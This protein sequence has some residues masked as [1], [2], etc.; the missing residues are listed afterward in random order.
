MASFLN[1]GLLKTSI[2]Y[3]ICLENIIAKIKYW[4]WSAWC[5]ICLLFSL[6]TSSL[7]Y[8]NMEQNQLWDTNANVWGPYII[9]CQSLA[10][11]TS[12]FNLS[13]DQENEEGG[14][15]TKDDQWIVFVLSF[16]VITRNC[17]II[18]RNMTPVIFNIIHILLIII[19]IIMQSV[20]QAC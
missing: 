1:F 4:N 17:H 6:L 18:I 12:K 14:W 20:R 2:I 9:F 3:L 13:Q 19:I 16:E 10:T 7:G 5:V 11:S 15:K 8:G